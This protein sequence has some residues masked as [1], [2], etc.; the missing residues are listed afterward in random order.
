VADDLEI[1]LD[2]VGQRDPLDAQVDDTAAIDLATHV[3]PC[4]PA[5]RVE[6]KRRPEY[7]HR[8]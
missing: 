2:A 7:P 4:L 5:R 1:D 3:G 8:P 6:K